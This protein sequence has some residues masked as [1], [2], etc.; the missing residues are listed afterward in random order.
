ME[1]Q[2]SGADMLQR[3]VDWE[4]NLRPAVASVHGLS[5][6]SK[7]ITRNNQNCDN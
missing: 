2:E 7:T 3:V 1:R 6:I 4:L 5:H